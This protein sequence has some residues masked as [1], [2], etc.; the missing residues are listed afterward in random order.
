M[1][2]AVLVAVVRVKGEKEKRRKGLLSFGK[3]SGLRL[4]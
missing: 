2:L 4:K 3:D 1:L